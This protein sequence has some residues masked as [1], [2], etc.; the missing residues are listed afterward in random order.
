M[1]VVT[2]G[3]ACCT[4]LYSIKFIYVGL[5]IGVQDRTSIIKLRTDQGLICTL[6][7][8]RGFYLYVALDKAKGAVGLGSN[9]VNV[10]IPG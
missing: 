9:P 3:P 5:S 10:V 8:I 4:F 7:Y 2:S 6:S 1:R